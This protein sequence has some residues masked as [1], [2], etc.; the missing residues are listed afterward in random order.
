MF[1]V[2]SFFFKTSW[3][4]IIIAAITSAF[5]AGLN[6]LGLKFIGEIVTNDD[7]DKWLSLG[8]AVAS[9]GAASIISLFAGKYILQHFELKTAAYRKE[10]AKKVFRTQLDRIEKKIDRLV[11]V[12]MFEI[13]SI[14]GFGQLISGF[15]VALFQ[16]VLILGYLFTLSWQMVLSLLP[17]FLVS[18]IVNI[19]SLPKFKKI[20]TQ[21]SDKRYRLHL[22][23]DRLEKGFKD[24]QSESNHLR[25][26]IEKSIDAPS[27]ALVSLNVQNFYLRTSISNIV[28]T[29]TIAYLGGLLLLAMNDAAFSQEKLLEFLALV[30]YIRPSINTLADFFNQVKV[31]EN[32]LEQV[33][34]LDVYITESYVEQAEKI[35]YNEKSKDVLIACQD[36]CFAYKNLGSFQMKEVSFEISPNEIVI[37]NGMN[38]SGKSTL[39]KLLLGLYQ[40]DEGKV[41]FQGQELTAFNSQSYRD[42]FACYFTDSPLFDDF[43]YLKEVGDLEDAQAVIE[44]LELHGKTKITEDLKIEELNL[45]HGQKGRLNLF[46]LLMEDKPIYFLDEWAA[47]QDI[48]FKEKFYKEIVP[49]L[50]K[51]GKTVILITHDDKYYNIADR[52]VT[53]SNGKVVE[54]VLSR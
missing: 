37:V 4:V 7:A 10:L 35:H 47:N 22:S 6:I 31:V 26:Y 24:L 39:F 28:N 54:E 33:E 46:R 27:K 40:P 52:V 18:T 34:S 14:G 45:S 1:S 5:A 49:N 30:L 41:V 44:L 51:R 36:V 12:L 20:E 42:L 2:I 32:A 19:I 9:L 16:S 53:L 50:K 17:V 25:H 38:G 11:P 15:L 29:L 8:F 23:L 13:G 43:G 21:L 48:H 3:Q